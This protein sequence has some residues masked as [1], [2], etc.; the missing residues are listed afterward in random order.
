MCYF[1]Q[2]KQAIGKSDKKSSYLSGGNYKQIQVNQILS[3]QK[4]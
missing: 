3:E 1:L 4:F 2:G